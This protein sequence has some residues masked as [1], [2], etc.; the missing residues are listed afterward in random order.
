MNGLFSLLRKMLIF[1][2]LMTDP[3]NEQDFY[4]AYIKKWMIHIRFVIAASIFMYASFSYLDYNFVSEHLKELSII[5]YAIFIPYATLLFLLTFIDFRIFRKIFEPLMFIQIIIAGLGIIAMI[6]IIPEETGWMYYAG[7]I[8]VI[9]ATFTWYRV[10]LTYATIAT[11]IVIVSYE[12]VAVLFKHSPTHVV[13]INSFFLIAS[14]F[15]SFIACRS[16]E[17]Y[18]RRDFIL[19]KELLE[20]N[21]KLSALSETDGLCGIAN[22]RKLDIHLDNECKRA[23]RAKT[24]MSLLL[25]DIDFFK[26][27]ND[28][29]GH[30]EGD[31]VLQKIAKSLNS[32][33]KRPGDLCARY[34]GEEFVLV[35]PGMDKDSLRIIAEEI[36]QAVRSLAIAHKDSKISDVIT[37]SAGAAYASSKGEIVSRDLLKMADTALYK[38]KEQGRNRLTL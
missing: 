29:Y 7:L 36:I 37:V 33:T 12:I 19:E 27:Y 10:R 31:I 9:I 26:L 13:I 15:M 14:A 34:G 25:I 1:V 5:R 38:S 23:N 17:L 22:R 4:T 28:G 20:S 3:E 21:R 30:L 18:A 6:F 8:L 2:F 16:M 11:I 35:F 24:E 32:V